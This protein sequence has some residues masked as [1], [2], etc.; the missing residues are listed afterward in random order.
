MALSITGLKQQYQGSSLNPFCCWVRGGGETTQALGELWDALASMW[1]C[2]FI[3]FAF[4]YLTNISNTHTTE[5]F[6]IWKPLKRALSL[7]GV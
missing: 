7:C 6:C 4:L 1:K 2:A 5:R 3:L